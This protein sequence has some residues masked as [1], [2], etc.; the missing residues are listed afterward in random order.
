MLVSELPEAQDGR[1]GP[2]QAAW[3]RERPFLIPE[4]S[5]PKK[6][7][8]PDPRS[9]PFTVQQRK[10]STCGVASLHVVRGEVLNVSTVG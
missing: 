4:K 1:A 3:I 5:A 2:D 10:R 8:C 7:E 9:R 6:T